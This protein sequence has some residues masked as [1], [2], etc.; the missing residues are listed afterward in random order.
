M[1]NKKTLPKNQKNCYN[2]KEIKRKIQ[3]KIVTLASGS[4]GN[5]T[6][7]Q[8]EKVNILID[9]GLTLREL[10]QKLKSV[11]VEPASIHAILITHEHSDHI[12]GLSVFAKK[13]KTKIYAHNYLW[14]VLNDKLKDQA[15]I[16]QIVFFSE[17][18]TLF[19]LTVTSFELPHDATYCVGYSFLNDGKKISI[20]TDLG[21]TNPRIIE[22]L[23]NSTLLILEA[24]HDEGLLK[25]NPKYPFYLKN[26][27]LSSKGHLS[28]LAAA[29]TILQLINHNVQQVVLA[30]LS[31]ENNAPEMAYNTVKDFLLTYGVEEGK[32]IFIDVATQHKVGNIFHLK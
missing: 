7:L 20:A 8:T 3:M 13:Y 14:Q 16:E 12:K 18:F 26:R 31:E 24:N 23:K 1:Q 17:D 19:D 32:H 22:Q 27:I 5:S 11:H 15:L 29:Q 25:Q 6:F 21:H 30:H 28:N 4:K 2:E 9:A 10:E